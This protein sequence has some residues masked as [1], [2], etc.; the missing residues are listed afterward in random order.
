MRDFEGPEKFF[1]WTSQLY[2]NNSINELVHTQPPYSNHGPV[3]MTNEQDFI[4]MGPST[5]GL[6]K[7]NTGNHLMLNI[8]QSDGG[9]NGIFNVGLNATSY[10]DTSRMI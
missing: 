3:P 1:E 7:N 6:I 9:Y 10:C 4:F 5:D 8:S 2:L